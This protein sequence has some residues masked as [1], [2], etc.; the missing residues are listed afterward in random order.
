MLPYSKTG[1]RFTTSTHYYK[2]TLFWVHLFVSFTWHSCRYSLLSHLPT[3]M[4]DYLFI[5]KYSPLGYDAYFKLSLF[6]LSV[7]SGFF[8]SQFII[9]LLVF[10]TSKTQVLITLLH[11]SER[12]SPLYHRYKATTLRARLLKATREWRHTP[13]SWQNWNPNRHHA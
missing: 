10:S 6:S 1:T 4:T 9:L 5:A 3:M 12:P 11:G 7:Y 8:P 13:S 2:T